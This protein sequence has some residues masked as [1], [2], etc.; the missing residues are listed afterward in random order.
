MNRARMLPKWLFPWLLPQCELAIV[1]AAHAVIRQGLGKK[2]EI[3]GP[4]AVGLAPSGVWIPD[5]GVSR[6]RGGG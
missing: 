3:L 6:Y 4:E 1:I 5:Q 2:R